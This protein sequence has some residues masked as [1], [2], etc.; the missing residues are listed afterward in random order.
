MGGKGKFNAYQKSFGKGSP[1]GGYKGWDTSS[2]GEWV[3]PSRTD[4]SETLP[5]SRVLHVPPAHVDDKPNEALQD[6]VRPF[7]RGHH[8]CAAGELYFEVAEVKGSCCLDLTVPA[9]TRVSRGD[10]DDQIP[11]TLGEQRFDSSQALHHHICLMRDS[12]LKEAAAVDY[13]PQRL[14]PVDERVMRELFQYHPRAAEKMKGVKYIQ[15]G[16]NPH[17][18]D[19]GNFTF[20]V[21]RNEQ[22]GDDISYVKCLRSLSETASRTKTEHLL[23]LATVLLNAPCEGS[24]A[25]AA[26]AAGAETP[27]LRVK[28]AYE[29]MVLEEARVEALGVRVDLERRFLFL[30]SKWQIYGP[31]LLG[32]TSKS[33]LPLKIVADVAGSARLS[34]AAPFHLHQASI[35]LPEKGTSEEKK[36]SNLKQGLEALMKNAEVPGDLSTLPAEEVHRI[37]CQ[38]LVESLRRATRLQRS[39]RAAQQQGRGLEILA[40][41]Q[42]QELMQEQLQQVQAELQNSRKDRENLEAANEKLSEEL[43]QLRRQVEPPDTGAACDAQMDAQRGE[44]DASRI[45]NVYKQQSGS[46]RPVEELQQL[47][48][49]LR[50][51]LPSHAASML[52]NSLK[53]MSSEMY[54]GPS[55]A[56]WE[57]LQNADDCSYGS[58]PALKVAHAAEYLWLEYNEV[59]FSFQDVEALCSLGTSTKGM[60]LNQTGYK[61]IGFK[62]SFVL[63]KKPHVLSTYQ[64]F[65]DEDDD[66]ALPQV[67]PQLLESGA[68][69][70]RAPPMEG[71]AIYLPFRKAFPDLL[72]DLMPSTL[73]FLRRLQS[74]TVESEK[75]GKF[76]Y[77][78]QCPGSDRRE[79]LQ[80]VIITGAE[81]QEVET[82]DFY[83]SQLPTNGD[84]SIAFP[85]TGS[86]LT[87]A[88]VSATL[89]LGSLVG[90][91]TPLNAPFQLTANREA[92]QE[93]S[94]KNAALRDSL[95][96]LWLK[97]VERSEALATRAWLLQPG[98][99]LGQQRFW[100]PFLQRVAAGLRELPLVPVRGRVCSNGGPLRLPMS[101][102]RKP[103]SPLLAQLGLEADLELLG[104]GIPSEEYMAQLPP[105]ANPG[106]EEFNSKDLLQLLQKRCFEER[107]ETWRKTVVRALAK[108]SAELDLCELRR[109]PLFVL[110][111]REEVEGEAAGA[112]KTKGRAWRPCGDGHIFSSVP[113]TA[114]PGLLKVLD[115]SYA[116]P[117]DKELLKLMGCGVKAT[118]RDVAYAIVQ[119]ALGLTV[120]DDERFSWTNLA[121]LGRHWDAILTSTAADAWLSQQTPEQMEELLR[122]LLVPESTGSVLL[123]ARELCCP[124][125]IGCKPQLGE[126][127]P[128]GRLVREPPSGAS[129]VQQRLWWELV[130]M[131]L[132]VKTL[133]KELVTV[134]LPK[135]LFNFPK[136][137]VCGDLK[138]LLDFYERNGGLE[139]LR[140]CC[141]IEDHTGHTRSAS[142][143][144]TRRLLGPAFLNLLGREY[145]VDIGKAAQDLAERLLGVA[146]VPAPELILVRLQQAAANSKTYLAALKY[147]AE[148]W[149]EQ[150]ISTQRVMDELKRGLWLHSEEGGGKAILK[151]LEM[152]SWQD[153]EILIPPWT[154]KK[155][156][157]EVKDFMVKGLGLPEAAESQ[158]PVQLT[159]EVAKDTSMLE[160]DEAVPSQE[161]QWAAQQGGP[162]A[163]NTPGVRAKSTPGPP[164]GLPA[165][166]A[167]GKRPLEGGDDTAASTSALPSLPLLREQMEEQDADAS[168]AVPPPRTAAAAGA[169]GAPVHFPPL[170]VLARLLNEIYHENGGKEFLHGSKVPEASEMPV[171]QIRFTQNSVSARFL[172]GKMKG[173][174][175]LDVV[176]ELLEG[177]LSP[178]DLQVSV[179]KF[180]EE[181]WTLNNRSLYV[182]NKASRQLPGLAARVAI[183]QLCPVTAKFLQLRCS[184]LAEEADAP[185]SDSEEDAQPEF[186]AKDEELLQGGA[187]TA[188]G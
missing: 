45:L 102:C 181:Y 136:A 139:W 37:A 105:G 146:L 77:Q 108:R 12:Y 160:A 118:P 99:E 164:S 30:H 148:E 46:A 2:Q 187:E 131:R 119:E 28:L 31:Y 26:G 29:E 92:L 56:F 182:L 113:K 23:P 90:L 10:F 101:R 155:H 52:R 53:L 59:G 64:F 169:A 67:T 186:N 170:P 86:A 144:Q 19:R 166:G 157:Q 123:D 135:K 185:E 107:G 63:S 120:A 151:Q 69:L 174:R 3:P 91:R 14:R 50:S 177:K 27:G 66:C 163:W 15:V 162:S 36:K 4:E 173:R 55:R 80:R 95:A 127:F 171:A 75:A 7:F 24:T 6:E 84:V 20:W 106:L 149:Q 172:H 140:T 179:V 141:Q 39:R 13:Q 145:V 11:V 21:M 16:P 159:P 178:A 134:C 111:E 126:S 58:A 88:V 68:G 9:P 54:S 73:L 125:V 161:P 117:A 41:N 100:A 124:Y 116:C 71:T 83:V 22:D 150:R 17:S 176:K 93:G 184:S 62:A 143:D 133:P 49:R 130:F 33:H 103:E 74:I 147:L 142:E 137:E 114:P 79:G 121:Y 8:L 175:L 72:T 40:R 97:T 61:G 25:G 109:A 82:Q 132:G 129:S 104:L 152:A 87:S 128:R 188:D 57:L 165:I 35:R 1:K 180:R 32:H 168:E 122:S 43:A 81:G 65:F 153:I 158:K 42:A 38:V 98:A 110:T 5:L 183:F 96:E 115:P 70:P 154:K 138:A 48:R 156:R 78:L 76:S 44:E 85:M 60:G 34:W 112:A 94:S 89:P 18:F 51:A 47:S 167:E